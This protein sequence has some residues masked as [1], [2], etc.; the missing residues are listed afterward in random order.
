MI[1]FSRCSK[2]T[3]CNLNEMPII[4]NFILAFTKSVYLSFQDRAT[5]GRNSLPTSTVHKACLPSTSRFVKHITR[6]TIVHFLSLVRWLCRVLLTDW[7]IPANFS[8]F[9]MIMIIV[10]VFIYLV[11]CVYIKK[12]THTHSV[13][14]FFFSCFEFFSFSLSSISWECSNYEMSFNSWEHSQNKYMLHLTLIIY[15]ICLSCILVVV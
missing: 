4:S 15:S 11:K 5:N 9:T 1:N 13:F 3:L 14:F 10:F 2:L 6:I 12:L 7:L 8:D